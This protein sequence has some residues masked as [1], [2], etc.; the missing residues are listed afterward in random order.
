MWKD[1]HYAYLRY[2]LG[3]AGIPT[4]GGGTI[5]GLGY[6]PDLL[7]LGNPVTD[8]FSHM[9]L[10]LTTPQVNGIANPY[11]NNYSSYGELI[12]PAKADGFLRAAYAEADETLALGRE[13]MGGSPTTVAA[14]RPRVRRPVAGRQRRQ[15]ALRRGPAEQRRH[16]RRGVQQLPCG[17]G[18][19]ALN[20]AKACWAGGTAQIYVNSTLPAGTTYEQVRT[21]VI[22]A[23]QPW[24]TRPT[25]ARR[26]CSRS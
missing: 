19:G 2:I 4:I 24:P 15:G 11:Y 13:L 23:F 16:A 26:S 12:T 3:T 18:T 20:L 14:L 25:P 6:K 1:A 7:M 17:I 8:E 22:N 5:A 9:F 10:G 21:A